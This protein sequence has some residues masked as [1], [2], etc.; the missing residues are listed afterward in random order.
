MA[1]AL[2]ELVGVQALRAPLRRLLDT[3]ALSAVP[4]LHDPELVI[5]D[6]QQGVLLLELIDSQVHR[7]DPFSLLREVLRKQTLVMAPLDYVCQLTEE[8]LADLR[9]VPYSVL[10]PR[11]RLVRAIRLEGFFVLAYVAEDFL[12]EFVAILDYHLQVLILRQRL[13]SFLLNLIPTHLFRV[14]L[15][16]RYVQLFL[17][18]L[19]L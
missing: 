12:D 8:S 13:I 4:L 5:L 15:L 9:E 17:A 3:N 16:P 14:Q 1:A 6:R 7:D 19:Q 2:G 10:L 11:H 18:L